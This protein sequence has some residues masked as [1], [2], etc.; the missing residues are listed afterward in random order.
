LR[1]PT[2]V[3]HRTSTTDRARIYIIIQGIL[4]P[5]PE[6]VGAAV[7]EQEARRGA[8][9]EGPTQPRRKWKIGAL[10]A[11]VAASVALAAVVVVISRGSDG[12]Q[13][14]IAARRA[15]V[16]QR[17]ASVMPFDQNATMHQ[18]SKTANGG[19]QSVTANDPQDSTQIAVI[20]QHLAR[21]RD[22]FAA[23][24]FDD[25]M[26]IHGMDMPGIAGLQAA[27]AAGQITIT[28]TALPN[29]A[30]LAYSTSENGVLH[31]L[32]TWF[33]AQLMDHG[34]HATP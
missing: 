16:E 3:R 28:Y 13:A 15:D 10:V 25:P 8:E 17:G 27:A 34:S 19:I 22:L 7:S 24:D 33:D 30:R 32:H 6:R 5:T 26:A 4:I 29:G 2:G 20:R 11:V 21:E 9:W 31:A 18:F 23:G 1:P 12:S 14:Q